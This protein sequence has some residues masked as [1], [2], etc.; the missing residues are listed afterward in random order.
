MRKITRCYYEVL[1]VDMDATDEDLK[2]AY[3]YQAL[4]WHPDKNQSDPE[5][6]AEKFLELQTAFEILSDS[7]KRAWYD[8]FRD[9]ILR[10]VEDIVDDKSIDLEPFMASSCYSGYGDDDEG[11]YGVYRKLFDEIIKEEYLYQD[12]DDPTP[13]SFG[14]RDTDYEQ[15]HAFYSY[16]NSFCTKKTFDHLMKYD[17]LE[18]PN[19]RVLRLMEKENIKIRD[20]AKKVRNEA[21][22]KLVTFVRKKDRRVLENKKKLN[23]KNVANREKAEQNRRTQFMNHRKTVEEHSGQEA[24]WASMKSLERSLKTLERGLDREK[25]VKTKKELAKELLE[26]DVDGEELVVLSDNEDIS[27]QEND[28]AG[29]SEDEEEEEKESLLCVACRKNFK[30]VNSFQN[31]CKSKKHQQN[32]SLL[33][34]ALLEDEDLLTS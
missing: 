20:Q 23:D 10:G 1:D 33:K 11:F 31:H 4:R 3:K 15:V 17:I 13:P 2:K 21:V 16:W 6:A 8:K 19:R 28:D 25:E 26:A 12:E 7:K 22:R 5:I 9:R 30:S 34:E 27:G 32:V 14:N 29:Q 24:D 18:A